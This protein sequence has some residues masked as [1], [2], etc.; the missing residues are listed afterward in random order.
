M[1][2]HVL[3]LWLGTKIPH[4]YG[5]LSPLTKTGEIPRAAPQTQCNQI[6]KYL[7]NGNCLK[8]VVI[9]KGVKYQSV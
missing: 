2:G 6:N 9:T 8:A 4:A 3:N 5:Q 7:K 1:R